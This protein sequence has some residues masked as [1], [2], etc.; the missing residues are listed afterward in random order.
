[1]FGPFGLTQISK[2]SLYFHANFR[3]IGVNT[4]FS[5]AAAARNTRRVFAAIG[6]LFDPHQ[7]QGHNACEPY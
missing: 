2:S 5:I 4:T 6:V 7:L 1:M 3:A